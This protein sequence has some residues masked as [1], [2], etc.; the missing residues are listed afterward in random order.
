MLN[1]HKMIV[2]VTHPWPDP[3]SGNDP[4]LIQTP[5]SS[6]TWGNYRFEVNNSCTE[7]DYWIIAD[8]TR[9]LEKVKVGA[10]NVI[11]LTTEEVDI[12]TYETGYLKQ[13]DHIITSRDDI[14]QPSVIHSHY[15]NWWFVKKSLDELSRN[16]Y[17][18]KT[19]EISIVSSNLTKTEGHKNRYHFVQHLMQHFGNRLDVFGRG[20]HFIDDK[21]D[22]IAPYKYSLAIENSAIKDYFT[23]KLIDC[24]LC[25]TMPIYYGCPNISQY[26]NPK[27]M[28]IL[29]IH[30]LELS[31]QTIEKAIAEN[32]YAQSIEY[33]QEA[34]QLALQ[35]YQFF[36]TIAGILDTLNRRQTTTEKKTVTIMP[37]GKFNSS[38]KDKNG[39]RVL[40]QK[41]IQLIRS[42]F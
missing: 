21:F 2:K 42:R 9:T 1:A 7:C 27:S 13:F 33:I 36:P 28:I 8:D 10:R 26:F 15:I 18:D 6:G 5:D 24:Y 20:H 30:N 38:A 4:I 34:K 32:L 37:Q 22:A 25:N 12:K 31:I 3:Q 19:K 39:Y 23:E 35:Q 17:T 14:Q 40:L 29:D 41:G 11:L 16:R